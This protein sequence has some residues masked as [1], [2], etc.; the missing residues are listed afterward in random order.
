MKHDGGPQ[1]HVDCPFRCFCCSSSN[2]MDRSS[3]YN[4]LLKSCQIKK[5]SKHSSKSQIPFRVCISFAQQ[6]ISYKTRCFKIGNERLIFSARWLHLLQVS[7]PSTQNS[8]KLCFP[9]HF[10]IFVFSWAW[11]LGC[12][13]GF[14]LSANAL[15]WVCFFCLISQLGKL[16]FLIFGSEI[17]F[18]C[19]SLSSWSPLC[20][21]VY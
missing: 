9:F 2:P 19:F 5:I 8:C 4:S 11:I 1:H 3:L 18:S 17:V 16:R 20:S 6:F 15:C 7:G 12:K 21:S 10:L 14:I 13:Y